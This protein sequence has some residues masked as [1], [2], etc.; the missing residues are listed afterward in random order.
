MDLDSL[1]R[2]FDILVS[3]HVDFQLATSVERQGTLGQGAHPTLWSLV[4]PQ[5]SVQVVDG[6][7]SAMAV[8]FRTLK[9][10]DH[11]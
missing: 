8:A 1:V 10:L 4:Q 9:N 3:L 6:S 11:S 7:E 5:V 2:S